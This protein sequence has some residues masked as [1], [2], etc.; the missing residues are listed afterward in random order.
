MFQE[1]PTQSP[2]KVNPGPGSTGSHSLCTTS[3]QNEGLGNSSSLEVQGG[4]PIDFALHPSLMMDAT[5][6]HDGKWYL[7][8]ADTYN[9]FQLVD[10]SKA[11]QKEIYITVKL[12][13][14]I[15]ARPMS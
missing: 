11:R 4:G 7:H 15:H 3:H 13:C 8:E 6:Y 1:P 14:G 5:W 10:I 2:P 9:F 12:G